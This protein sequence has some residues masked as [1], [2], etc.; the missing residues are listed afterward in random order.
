MQIE[1]FL[2]ENGFCPI[3]GYWNTNV[4]N[5]DEINKEIIQTDYLNTNSARMKIIEMLFAHSAG[6]FIRD[7]PKLLDLNGQNKGLTKVIEM[8]E[9]TVVFDDKNNGRFVVKP[10]WYYYEDVEIERVLKKEEIT[11]MFSSKIKELK[12][13]RMFFSDEKLQIEMIKQIQIWITRQIE[14]TDFID[15]LYNELP[16]LYIEKII[17]L[18]NTLIKKLT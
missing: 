9:I 6:L 14:K 5:D 16:E 2:S 13:L 11:D 12:V 8:F 10:D 7:I 4:K 15:K 3:D 18:N 1:N 17:D